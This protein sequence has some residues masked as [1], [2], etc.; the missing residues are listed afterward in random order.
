MKLRMYDGEPHS[1]SP[2]TWIAAAFV[3]AVCA[4]WAHVGADARWLAAIGAAIVHGG[5][6]P[7]AVA[8]AAAAS[9]GW[10]DAPALGQLV[11]HGVESL[12]GDKGLVALNVVA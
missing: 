2:L 7:H 8:Y 12:V 5:A 9:S 1:A 6:V 10:H 11:F 3:A 4:A